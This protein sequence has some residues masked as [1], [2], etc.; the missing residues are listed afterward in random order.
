LCGEAARTHVA[1]YVTAG[2]TVASASLAM[3]GFQGQPDA[4]TAI[5]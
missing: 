1:S 4:R 3:A 5:T 2:R